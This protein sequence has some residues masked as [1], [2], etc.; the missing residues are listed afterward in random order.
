[1][2]ACA[3]TPSACRAT[4]PPERQHRRSDPRKIA[5]VFRMWPFRRSLPTVPPEQRALFGGASSA[6][7]LTISATTAMRCT[8]V[9][10][11]VEAISESVG[12]LPL[13]LCQRGDDGAWD[14]AAEHPADGLLHD[15]ANDRTPAALVR[16]QITRDGLLHGNGFGFINRDGTGTPREP[17][18]VG[19]EP[20]LPRQPGQHRHVG[21]PQ[22]GV[23]HQ[24]PP[25]HADPQGPGSA[26]IIAAPARCGFPRRRKP[27]RNRGWRRSR[28]PR[29]TTR[30]PSA[31][32]LSC[33]AGLGMGFGTAGRKPG[34]PGACRRR[35]SAKRPVGGWRKPGVP[36]PG[37]WLSAGTGT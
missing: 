35:D 7:G 14:R 3:F 17:E 21:R 5:P 9:R 27:A 31:A 20:G 6:T 1:M 28:R 18:P 37:S 19:R 12:G 2:S 8:P 32:S 23:A 33:P 11:A 15:Q 13:H 4:V 10:A 24:V 36:R 30:T 29:W 16:L 26:T 34:C 25:C 22:R